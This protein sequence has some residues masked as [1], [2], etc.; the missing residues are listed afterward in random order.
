MNRAAFIEAFL[1]LT[2]LR[3]C[4]RFHTHAVVLN[5]NNPLFLCMRHATRQRDLRNQP[6]TEVSQRG[7]Q[8]QAEYQPDTIH[9]L[10]PLV[11]S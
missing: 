1:L 9:H 3:Q 10:P 2:K 4:G 8:R 5:V 11:D 6:A 7:K